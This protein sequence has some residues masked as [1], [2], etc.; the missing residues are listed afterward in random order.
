MM[1][2]ID[3]L[4]AY[5][6]AYRESIDQPEKYWADVASYLFWRRK[7]DKVLSWDFKKPEV[8]WFQGGELNIA[9]NCLDIHL[10]GQPDKKALIWEPNDPSEETVTYTYRELQGKDCG[11]GIF[12][13]W[14]ATLLWDILSDRESR[15]V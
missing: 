3:S 9:E 11:A 5:N 14:R 8:K 4:E 1:T 10:Y 12:S 7:W 15:V 13:N 2:P 6:I